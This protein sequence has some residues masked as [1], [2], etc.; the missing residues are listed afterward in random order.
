MGEMALPIPP[1]KTSAYSNHFAR[2][3]SDRL[4]ARRPQQTMAALRKIHARL[5]V[6]IL[7]CRFP[8]LDNVLLLT[9]LIAPQFTTS[10]CLFC[11]RAHL[12][13]RLLTWP[14]AWTTP[15]RCAGMFSFS[16]ARVLV[17]LHQAY[18]S[19]LFFFPQRVQFTPGQIARLRAMIKTYRGIST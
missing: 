15:M 7:V 11:Q 14:T 17:A 19:L 4:A 6:M 8:Y 12:M 18:L 10:K 2:N 16:S 5:P 9:Y 13:V 1:L 3:C